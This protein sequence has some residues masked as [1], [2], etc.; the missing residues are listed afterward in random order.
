MER[1]AELRSAEIRSVLSAVQLDLQVLNQVLDE[2]AV[3][4]E[5]SLGGQVAQDLWLAQHE[6]A[7]RVGCAIDQAEARKRQAETRLEKA[8]SIRV[9]VSSEVELLE[10]LRAKHHGEYRHAASADHQNWLDALGLLRWHS[11]PV[12]GST[13]LVNREEVSNP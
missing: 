11:Q 1:Q 8:E 4:M 6:H 12:A 9:R 2:S 10:K 7:L 3:V 5:A 13:G